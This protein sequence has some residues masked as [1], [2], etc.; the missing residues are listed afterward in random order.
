MNKT[1]SRCL[2]I[3][4]LL[5]S[6]FGTTAFA[7]DAPRSD[8]NYAGLLITAI[9]HRSVGT[10]A[11]DGWGQAGTVVIGGHLNKLI[12]AEVRLG[13]G[14]AD[15]DITGGDLALAVDYFGSWYMGI[16]YPLG[17]LG[18]IY[19]QAGFSHI[20]GEAKLANAEEDNNARFRSLEGDYPGS[21]FSVSWLAGI[22]L[23]LR[24]DTY[25]VLEA[26]KLF[27]DTDSGVNA[28]QF[29][30]GFRYEF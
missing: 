27:E 9:E 5:C 30:S 14:Y 20:S 2:G 21:G 12:H 23:E 18:N 1:L 10:P 16:H 13:A 26:G 15:A 8:K 4:L 17:H 25:L 28:F 7:E 11:E 19:L 24:P 22:D 3:G 6:V 29:S